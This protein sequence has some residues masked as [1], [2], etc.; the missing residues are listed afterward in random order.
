MST[1][2]T[3]HARLLILGSGPA[4]YTAAV[5]AARANLEPV[6]LAGSAPGG[7]GGE[8]TVERTRHL[9]RGA[10]ILPRPL[11]PDLPM[12]IG[13]S[14]DAAIQSAASTATSAVSTRRRW[15]R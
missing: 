1:T 3:K 2:P 5:Y 10:S 15:V 13:G 12:W 8:E 9:R 6:V 7:A 11:Q 4:G 14:S